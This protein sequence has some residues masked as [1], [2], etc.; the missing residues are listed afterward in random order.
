MGTLPPADHRSEYLDGRDVAAVLGL[1][2]PQLRTQA[3]LV[4]GLPVLE[5]SDRRLLVAGAEL[6]AWERRSTVGSPTAQGCLVA[7]VRLQ[8]LLRRSRARRRGQDSGPLLPS[9]G[10]AARAASSLP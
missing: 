9:Q 2:V 8:A 1:T 6:D 3:T 10:D 5:V 4:G 7:A